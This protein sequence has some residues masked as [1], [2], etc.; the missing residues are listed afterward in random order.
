MKYV[1]VKNR[2]K[3]RHFIYKSG[4][5]YIICPQHSYCISANYN[6]MV[7]FEHYLKKRRRQLI[8]EISNKN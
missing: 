5:R 3:C 4:G 8:V 7:S 2:T 6:N 1:K